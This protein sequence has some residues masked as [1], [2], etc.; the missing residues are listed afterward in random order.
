[1]SPTEMFDQLSITHHLTADTTPIAL[2]SIT[3]LSITKLKSGMLKWCNFFLPHLL[4][5]VLVNNLYNC[6]LYYYMHQ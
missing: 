2:S 3:T 5:V 6:F 4:L 1:M